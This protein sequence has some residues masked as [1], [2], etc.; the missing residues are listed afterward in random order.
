MNF[1]QPV[2]GKILVLHLSHIS[3]KYVPKI[4]T[5]FGELDTALYICTHTHIHTYICTYIHKFVIEQLRVVKS[6]FICPIKP[7]ETRE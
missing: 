3:T 2:G 5:S 1:I 7:N 6:V 4:I